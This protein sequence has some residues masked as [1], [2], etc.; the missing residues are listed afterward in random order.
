MEYKEILKCIIAAYIVLRMNHAV[1]FH[2][3]KL[4][5][6]CGRRGRMKKCPLVVRMKKVLL[7]CLSGCFL[8]VTNKLAVGVYISS[9]NLLFPWEQ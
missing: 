4:S 1:G 5:N 7:L 9:C 6:L 8:N 2:L 3:Y